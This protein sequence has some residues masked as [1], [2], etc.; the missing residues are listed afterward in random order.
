MSRTGWL[1]ADGDNRRLEVL[2][3]PLV[4]STKPIYQP[5]RQ[6]IAD[7]G[8]VLAT[9]QTFQDIDWMLGEVEMSVYVPLASRNASYSAVSA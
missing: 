8:L 9:Q 7:H 4:K 2:E 6:F 5:V 3:S 1:I